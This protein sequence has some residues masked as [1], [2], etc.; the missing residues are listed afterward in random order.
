[1]DHRSIVILDRYNVFN[2]RKG[3]IYMHFEKNPVFILHNLSVCVCVCVKVH[4]LNLKDKPPF[5]NLK[6]MRFDKHDYANPHPQ[7]D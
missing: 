7:N 3:K 2:S 4:H 1:M 5:E 6:C